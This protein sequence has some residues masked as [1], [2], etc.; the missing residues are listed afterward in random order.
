M[1]PHFTGSS[2]LD[3]DEQF[4]DRVIADTGL[5][6]QVNPHLA[7]MHAEMRHDKL[8]Y[9]EQERADAELRGDAIVAQSLQSEIEAIKK[10]IRKSARAAS[11]APSPFE[12]GDI[13]RIVIENEGDEQD[14]DRN[15]TVR[16]MGQIIEEDDLNEAYMVQFAD[17]RECWYKAAWITSQKA[18]KMAAE[19]ARR[20]DEADAAAAA[21]C[22]SS[23]SSSPSA[24]AS[25]S[26][27]S[28]SRTTPDS[29]IGNTSGDIVELPSVSQ[30]CIQMI[31]E[32]SQK[33]ERAMVFDRAGAYPG[34]VGLYRE[35]ASMLAEALHLMPMAHPDTPVMETHIQEV[36]KRANYLQSLGK[37]PAEI[38]LEEMIHGRQLQM[39]TCARGTD[40]MIAAGAVLGIAG[41][42]LHGPLA[43]V[44]LA[45]G[46]AYAT[47]RQDGWGKAARTVGDVGLS[48]ADQTRAMN[49]KYKLDQQI[50][51]KLGISE[52]VT[53]IDE[54]LHLSQL[55]NQAGATARTV[56]ERFSI[57]EKTTA[58]AEQTS[59]FVKSVDRTLHISS[60]AKAAVGK[61]GQALSEFN[62]KHQITGKV[63]HTV[64]DATSRFTSWASKKA[65]SSMTSSSSR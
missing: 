46:A 37:E 30:E 51:G 23:S 53:M 11:Q 10:D 64:S 40:T 39:G 12:V 3:D 44:A 38:P 43:A 8:L 16:K 17:G 28:S 14:P 58:A 19:A 5:N 15:G 62:E 6:T 9:L 63:S 4:L 52:K 24:S 54:T 27:S 57:A 25:T 26:F 21:A 2:S 7:E 33:E 45:G 50:D 48:A 59:A 49:E 56:N 20:K 55:A 60:T 41:L 1:L 13:V 34:A 42:A 61:T 31:I 32:G 65:F 47:T 36:H 22:A 29:S 18:I 35:A